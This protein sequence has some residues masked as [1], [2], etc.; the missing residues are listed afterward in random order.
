MLHFRGVQRVLKKQRT[1]K[2]GGV[3]QL[4]NKVSPGDNGGWWSGEA[5]RQQVHKEKGA[6]FGRAA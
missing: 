6:C 1:A 5:E 4:T 3:S 2:E